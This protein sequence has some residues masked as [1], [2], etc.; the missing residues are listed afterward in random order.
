MTQQVATR[1]TVGVD[2]HA[3]AHVAVAKDSFGRA[4]DLER[5]FPYVSYVGAVLSNQCFSS[6]KRSVRGTGVLI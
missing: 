2:T 3:D 1:V 5:V 4:W 6:E